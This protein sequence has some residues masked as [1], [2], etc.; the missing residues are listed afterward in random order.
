MSPPARRKSSGGSDGGKP[1]PQYT[2]TPTAA[3]LALT[4]RLI[5][6]AL[7]RVLAQYQPGGKKV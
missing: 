2:Y 6:E 1:P 5:D 4:D 7:D 3:N